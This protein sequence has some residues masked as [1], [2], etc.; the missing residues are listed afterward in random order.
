MA[1]MLKI[2]ELLVSRQDSET[3]RYSR[4]GVLSYD[5]HVFRFK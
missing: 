1:T 3:R 4:V 5:G 2:H